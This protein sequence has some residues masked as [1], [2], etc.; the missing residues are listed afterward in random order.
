MVLVIAEDNPLFPPFFKG[1]TSKI[2]LAKRGEWVVFQT[3]FNT[4]GTVTKG[5]ME[6]VGKWRKKNTQRRPAGS[7][8]QLF[9]FLRFPFFS[10]SPFCVSSDPFGVGVFSIDKISRNVMLPGGVMVTLE[11]LVLSLEVRVLPG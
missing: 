6:N 9:F 2:P 1:G 3:F 7:P 11:I 5:E 10:L 4:G 8:L